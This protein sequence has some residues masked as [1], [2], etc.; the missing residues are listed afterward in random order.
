MTQSK[1]DVTRGRCQ[2]RALE[3]EFEGKPKWVMHCHC[4]SCRRAVS[5]AVATY[6]GVDISQFRYLKGDPA[7]Y[8]SSPGVQRY[9]CPTCGSP[10]AY[11]GSRWPKEVHLFIGTLENPAKFPPTGHAHIGEAVAW[12]DVHDDLPRFERTVKDGKPVAKG[13]VAAKASPAKT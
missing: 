3:Y 1:T 2:C 4:E 8:Q 13:A 11:A 6:V 10:M 7:I 5:S 12:F 9:F